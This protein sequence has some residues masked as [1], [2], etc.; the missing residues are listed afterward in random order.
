MNIVWIIIIGVVV[1]AFVA[2][3]LVKLR[4]R[5]SSRNYH[6]NINTRKKRFRFVNRFRHLEGVGD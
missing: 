3:A 1:M 5:K 6:P 2:K 4:R